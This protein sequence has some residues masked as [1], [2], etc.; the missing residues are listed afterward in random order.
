MTDNYIRFH[1]TYHYSAG[2]VPPPDHYEYEL[3]LSDQGGML[4]FWNDYRSPSLESKKYFFKLDKVKVSKLRGLINNVGY[5][6]WEK[7]EETQLGSATEWIDGEDGFFIPAEI[8]QADRILVADLYLLI[9]DMV[10]NGIWKELD[11][12]KR[13]SA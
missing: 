10:P 9:K 3:S 8:N 4:E 13:E 6:T 5:K 12:T 2:S 11:S 1:Y 7:P